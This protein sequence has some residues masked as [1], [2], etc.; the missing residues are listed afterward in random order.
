MRGEDAG[1]EDDRQQQAHAVGIRAA[2]AVPPAT[3][4]STS[5][6]PPPPEALFSVAFC[7][8][9]LALA[10][11]SLLG[12]RRAA[13][14]SRSSPRRRRPSPAPASAWCRAGWQRR[15]RSLRRSLLLPW[16][17]P[18]GPGTFSRV[19]V[20]RRVPRVVGLRLRE[21]RQGEQGNERESDRDLAHA[22]SYATARPG[23]TVRSHSLLRRQRVPA[24]CVYGRGCQPRRKQSPNAVRRRRPRLER[25]VLRSRACASSVPPLA[26]YALPFLLVLYL[27]LEGG[28]Y[29]AIV[30]SEVGIAVWWIVLLGAAVGV[31][32]VARVTAVGW[33]GLGLLGA[34]AAWTA[35]GI[36]WSESSERSVAELGPR[37]H[38]PRRLRAR[39][40]RP[41][42]RGAAPHRRRASAPRS[43]WSACSPC[44]RG[45]TRPG[46]PPTRRRGSCPARR[47]ASTTRSTTGTASRR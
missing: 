35:L 10:M 17:S 42:P 32:P 37:R 40:P 4:F 16:L 22:P 2:V 11:G 23:L 29:D 43:P 30:R 47:R 21:R 18:P 28:G 36:S 3:C 1:A 25:E 20:P 44:S 27:A 41:G 33:V 13:W 24:L 31:L 39:A 45:C 46:S 34:F 14:S 5:P 8:A 7:R 9:V 12:R 15:R 26:G 6:R 38:L 19:L